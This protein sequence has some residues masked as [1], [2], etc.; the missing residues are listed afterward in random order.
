MKPAAPAA[1]VSSAAHKPA[2]A[3][4]KDVPAGTEKPRV[5]APRVAAGVAPVRSGRN[6][7]SP[8]SA[9]LA[10][11]RNEK[12]RLHDAKELE[13]IQQQIKEDEDPENADESEVGNAVASVAKAIAYI[14]TVIVISI[15]LSVFII[16]VGNDVYAFVKDSTP[17][18][19]TVPEYATINDI[20]TMLADKEIIRYPKIFKLYAAYKKDDGVFLPGDY[21]LNPSM[22]YDELLAAFKPK[23]VTGTSR[24]TIPE[25]YSTDEIITLLT[26]K[27]HIGTREGYI[28]VINNYDFDF[29]FIDEL[30]ENGIPDGRYYRLDGYLFPDTYEFYNSSTEEVVIRKMLKRFDEVFVEAYVTKTRELGYTIDELLTIASLVE[31]EAGSQAE[32]FDVSAVFNNRL[33]RPASFPYLESDATIVYAIMHDTGVRI[34]LTPDDTNYDSPYNTYTHQ[35]LPPGPL[36]NP[37]A[38]AIRAALYPSKN[39]YYYFVAWTSTRSL[40]AKT[41][42]EHL[43]NIAM[44]VENRVEEQTEE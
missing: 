6:E 42:E 17:A 8:F 44:I 13:R 2:P 29:W 22:N 12:T 23:V 25:G 34:N 9:A 28:D 31:E 14:V 1:H 40:F 26:E 33:K 10:Q 7:P 36:C 18:Q 21:T 11:K 39:G 19:V 15:F 16:Y 35:G 4:R 38:S 27:Y 30:E 20:S 5:A 32:F 37:S 24:V 43:E 3:E 41:Y